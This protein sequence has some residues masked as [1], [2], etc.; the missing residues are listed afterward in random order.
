MIERLLNLDRRIIFVFVFLGVVISLLVEFSFPIK[1][2]PNVRAVY[3]EIERMAAVGG[4]VLFSFDYGPGSEPELQPMA[5]SLLRHCFSRDVK[6]VVMCLW[7]DAPGLAQEALETTSKE[8]GKTYGVDY[9]FM[10]YKP[11]AAIVIINMGQDFRSAFPRDA[12]GV[13]TD[14]LEVTRHI[15]TLSDFGFVFDIAAGA[16]IDGA[17]IPYGQEKYKFPLAA[18]CTAVMAPDLFPYLQSRQLVGLVGGLAGAAEYESLVD[19]PG[20]AT[21]GM[22]PQSI[23]HLIIIAFIALGNVLYFVGRRRGSGGGGR[24]GS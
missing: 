15:R 9:A 10:G 7:P 12:G 1:A 8:F 23:T 11:G 22:R 2:T 17:W 3:E 16:S 5:L 19:R 20:T 21:A 24:V 18:G 4:T 6:V 13:R 14:S